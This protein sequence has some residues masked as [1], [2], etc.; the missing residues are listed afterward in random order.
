M[1]MTELEDRVGAT[2]RAKSDQVRVPDREFD[3][4]AV[5]LVPPAPRRRVPVLV[6]AVIALLIAVAIGVALVLVDQRESTKPAGEPTRPVSQLRVI[7]LPSLSY[8]AKEFTTE[9]GLNEIEL[10]SAGGTHGLT[11]DDPALRDVALAPVAEKPARATVMLEA[12]R[13]YTIHCVIPGHRAAGMEAV[14]HVTDGPAGPTKGSPPTR[15]DGLTDI[16]TYPDYIETTEGDG[17]PAY[18]KLLDYTNVPEQPSFPVY[19]EDLVTVVGHV[20][21]GRGFVALGQDTRSVPEIVTTTT[22]G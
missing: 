10:V 2:L 8:Q 20:V 16:N 6:A 5:A 18:I 3:P 22:T 21:A 11:F 12:G 17:R 13:D 15:D 9:P 4:D 14:I 1:T 7:A 19:A